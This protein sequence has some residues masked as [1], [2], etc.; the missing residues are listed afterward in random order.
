LMLTLQLYH[1]ILF[2]RP[3][4]CLF[5]PHASSVMHFGL[6]VWSVAIRGTV[7]YPVTSGSSAVFLSYWRH[8]RLRQGTARAAKKHPVSRRI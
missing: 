8:F 6:I 5:S 4:P 1:A 3:Q 7:I 2:G